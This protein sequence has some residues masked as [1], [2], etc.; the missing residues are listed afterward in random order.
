MVTTLVQGKVLV[1]SHETE[2]I[3]ELHP[4]ETAV[5]TDNQEIDVVTANV[6]EVVSWK[7]DMF[8]SAVLLWNRL[9]KKQHAGMTSG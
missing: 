4:G 1:S 8:V 3:I 2:D 5:V 7:D 6:Q 9:W